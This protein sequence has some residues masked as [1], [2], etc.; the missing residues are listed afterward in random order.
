[1]NKPVVLWC[2]QLCVKEKEM[3]YAISDIE[4]GDFDS[5]LAR[6]KAHSA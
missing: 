4:R 2:C 5:A 1:M 3:R 6:L